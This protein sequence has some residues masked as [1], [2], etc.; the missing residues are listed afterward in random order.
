MNDLNYINK[1]RN[2]AVTS[3]LCAFN[4]DI[5]SADVGSYSCTTL[6]F[7][8]DLKRKVNNSE[9]IAYLSLLGSQQKKAKLFNIAK[10]PLVYFR[11]VDDTFAVFNN[12]EDC[13]NFFI[14]LN[15]LHPSL[16]FT[17]EKKSNHSLLSLTC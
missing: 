4:S 3:N 1:E 14:Q 15:P 17:Y 16:R 13:N 2:F 5:L 6:N 9:L 12:E 11:Y 7:V 10:R 8:E